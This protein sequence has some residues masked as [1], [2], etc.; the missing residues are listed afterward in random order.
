MS[1]D[2]GV[3]RLRTLADYAKLYAT[4]DRHTDK[5]RSHCDA[6]FQLFHVHRYR[7]NRY[8]TEPASR[9]QF[10]RVARRQTD[11]QID[12]AVFVHVRHV[13][14]RRHRL[15]ELCGGGAVVERDDR[16]P[17]EQLQAVHPL[18]ILRGRHR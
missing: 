16:T 18:H 13:G 15:C 14:G 3:G 8:E 11:N 1:V 2:T 10:D 9:N 12:T 17:F 4:E 7:D 5:I 6:G